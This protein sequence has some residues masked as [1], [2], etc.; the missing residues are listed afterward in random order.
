MTTMK[1]VILRM[2]EE[3]RNAL[4]TLS[5]LASVSQ[6]EYIRQLVRAEWDKFNGNPELK[7]AYEQLKKITAE[8][9]QLNEILGTKNR[10]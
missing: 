1:P 4:A 3:D 6:A 5:E 8:M 10:K 7:K 2:T 9:E